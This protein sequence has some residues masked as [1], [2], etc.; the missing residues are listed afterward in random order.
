[1][2][3]YKKL[4]KYAVEPKQANP[5]DAGYDIVAT[6]VEHYDNFTEYGT[7][8]ALEIPEGY[9]GLLFARSSV[10]N[11]DLVLKN[12]VGVADSSFRGE[13]KF[14]FYRLKDI[15]ECNYYGVGERIGQLI[16]VKHGT[17]KPEEV[18]TLSETKRGT[19]GYGST[20][21]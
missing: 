20:G 7:G 10:T 13:L 9:V 15:A 18:I 16:L 21:N 5:G 2:F 14:R 12:A 17:G 4:N 1:M 6:N 19:G 3:K 8:L 11:K